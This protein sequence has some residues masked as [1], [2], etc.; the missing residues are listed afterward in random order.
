MEN[1]VVTV[2]LGYV[3][4]DFHALIDGDLYLPEESWAQDRS[5]CDEAKIPDDVVYR[6][7][8]K[9]ALDV[10][11]RS[12]DDGVRLRWITADEFYGRSKEFRDTVSDSGLNYVVEIPSN[13]SGASALSQVS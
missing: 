5:R 1:C 10:L 6:P 13:L 4:P 2:H 3:T 12:L 8:G 9:I 7:K 11:R